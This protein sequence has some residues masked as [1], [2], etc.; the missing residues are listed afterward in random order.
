MFGDPKC[1]Q[2]KKLMIN[3]SDLNNTHCNCN[4]SAIEIIKK[5]IKTANICNVVLPEH[6]REGMT[7]KVVISD[8]KSQPCCAENLLIKLCTQKP[9]VMSELIID[10]NMYNEYRYDDPYK[11]DIH[12]TYF[13]V[14]KMIAAA[15][16][17]SHI[18]LPENV[19]GK[20]LQIII[21][22]ITKE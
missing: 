11:K 15:S 22:D 1:I 6:F 13:H 2:S 20:D 14:L 7:L 3:V 10:E 12:G 9:Y 5:V 8:I 17:I 21:T 16:H 19:E 4:R 18:T